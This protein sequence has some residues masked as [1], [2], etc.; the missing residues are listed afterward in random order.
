MALN[1]ILLFIIFALIIRAVPKSEIRKWL[2]LVGSIFT[3]F[4]LQPSLPYRYLDFI[5]PVFVIMIAFWGWLYITPS[6]SRWNKKNL[7]TIGV[8]VIT[9]IVINLARF[10]SVKGVI[11]PTRPPQIWLLLTIIL[12]VGLVT[13]LLRA[14]FQGQKRTFLLFFSFIVLLLIGLKSPFI[15]SHLLNIG[16]KQTANTQVIQWLGFSYISFRILHTLLDCQAKRLKD[17]TLQEYMI[18]IFF[19]PAVAAGPIDR[20][21]RFKKDLNR[22]FEPVNLTEITQS[23]WRIFLGI[24]KKYAIADTLAL[25][26]INRTL[27]WQIEDPK[28]LLLFLYAYSFQIFF[29][30]SGYT[31]IAIGIGGL[32]GFSLPENFNHPYLNPNL[33]LFWDNW[34]MTLTQW[35]RTYFFNPVSRQIRKKYRLMHV[36]WL[37]LMMQLSTMLLIGLWHGVTVNFVIWGLWHGIGLFVENR[38]SAWISPKL[39]KLE[40]VWIKTAYQVV[41]CLITFHFVMLGWIWFALPTTHDALHVFQ[42]LFGIL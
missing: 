11:T 13:I 29:D 41:G 28:W 25:V 15:Q 27:V 8:I 18:Y 1:T 9:E 2:I 35:F 16:Y 34:H 19:F 5:L 4:W 33:K 6:E 12:V 26:A 42:M 23:G 39:D 20:I 14:K 17:V 37:V 38:W 32:L 3:V 36:G 24:F 21:Q 30:F 22:E 7:T 31:D 40:K 10:L